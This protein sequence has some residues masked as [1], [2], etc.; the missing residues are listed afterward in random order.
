MAFPGHAA[1]AARADTTE[2]ALVSAGVPSECARTRARGSNRGPAGRLARD[3]RGGYASS[4]LRAPL[5]LVLAMVLAIPAGA[6]ASDEAP[7]CKPAKPIDLGLVTVW[8]V[9]EANLR[10]KEGGTVKVRV[11][12]KTG[13]V[14]C[15]V[16]GDLTLNGKPRPVTCHEP[17]VEAGAE[18]EMLCSFMLLTGERQGGIS[19]PSTRRPGQP[20]QRE[21]EKVKVRVRATG[22]ELAD[23]KAYKEW[24]ARREVAQKKAREQAA[25]VRAGFRRTVTVKRASNA[26]EVNEF[27]DRS[28]ARLKECFVGRAQRNPKLQIALKLRLGVS[29]A[30]TGD[31]APE[32]LLAIRVLEQKGSRPEVRDCLAVLEL[33]SLPENL[34]FEAFADVNYQAVPPEKAV[35]P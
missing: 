30:R 28:F 19:I 27:L 15:R 22:M 21:G 9:G 8:P 2:I 3:L 33:T 7:P 1:T 16:L 5:L 4:M 35:E 32:N 23:A 18:T 14:V 20:A 24:E 17:A 13:R 25:A 12:N 11:T 26:K 31:G 34:D 10:A 29:K 6:G